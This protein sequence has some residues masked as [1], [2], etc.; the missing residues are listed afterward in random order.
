M[1]GS[2]S[3]GRFSSKRT[4]S[5]SGSRLWCYPKCQSSFFHLAYGKNNSRKIEQDQCRWHAFCNS[6]QEHVL[7]MAATVIILRNHN[8]SPTS[9]FQASA[10]EPCLDSSTAE[11]PQ[12]EPILRFGAPF[13]YVANVCIGIAT[14]SDCGDKPMIFIMEGI[15]DAHRLTIQTTTTGRRN[16]PFG[17]ICFIECR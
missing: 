7:P 8:G 13:S 6:N 17:R 4:M 11:Q 15:M 16:P 10:N 1:R 14:L 3:L 9:L 5:P 12:Y 2:A